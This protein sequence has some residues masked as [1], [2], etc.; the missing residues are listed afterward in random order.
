MVDLWK[1][2][3]GSTKIPMYIPFLSPNFL[4]LLV[5][6]LVWFI[7]KISQPPLNSKHLLKIFF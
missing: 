3:V 4:L 7:V 1:Y 5:F 6:L 2:C